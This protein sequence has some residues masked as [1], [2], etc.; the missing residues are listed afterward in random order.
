ME[1]E[2]DLFAV[3]WENLTLNQKKAL[4]IVLEKNGQS[5]YDEQ[6]LAKYH[7]KSGSFQTALGGLVQKDIIDK[8]SD[9]YYFADPL[10]EFWCKKI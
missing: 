6:Y 4:K 7:I 8:N 9:K 2:E 1:R 10:F 3:E 5:L